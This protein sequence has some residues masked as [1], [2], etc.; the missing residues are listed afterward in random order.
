MTNMKKG[1]ADIPLVS[2]DPDVFRD[3]KR[4]KELYET[5]RDLVIS[6]TM[7]HYRVRKDL[8]LEVYQEAFT[9]FFYQVRRGSLTSIRCEL[10]TYL[11]GIVKNLMK[12]KKGKYVFVAMEEISDR[13]AVD[14]LAEE[15]VSD[16]Y[17]KMLVQQLLA[18]IGDPCRTILELFYQE[19][20][21]L[22]SI[23]IDLEYKN[24]NVVKK[25]KS[26]CLKHLRDLFQAAR[27]ESA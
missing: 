9:I 23:A 3:E 10:Q 15:K 21:S 22:E 14:N 13:P 6:W 11:T 19:R 4:A 17:N 7:K 26:L 27:N 2:F 5:H 12:Q 24:A 1:T 25:K 18:K 20:Y 16:T 8:A